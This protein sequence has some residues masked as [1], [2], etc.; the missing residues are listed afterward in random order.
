M[1][2]F[3]EDLRNSP[4][5]LRIHIYQLELIDMIFRELIIG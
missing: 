4:M 1:S 5:D 2:Q 3:V